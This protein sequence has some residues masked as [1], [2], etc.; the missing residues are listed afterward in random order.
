MYIIALLSSLM[1][2]VLHVLTPWAFD[3]L[4]LR[5]CKLLTH[6]PMLVVLHWYA[7][8]NIIGR[9]T[10]VPAPAITAIPTTLLPRP[11]QGN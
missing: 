10:Y 3:Q 6:M 7:R 9:C 2:F 4:Q 8:T 1:V 5:D 11:R